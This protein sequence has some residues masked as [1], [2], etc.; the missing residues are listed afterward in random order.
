MLVITRKAD[1]EIVIGDDIR[2][3]VTRIQG[4]RVRIGIDAPKHVRV[5]RAE[6][7]NRRERA[8]IAPTQAIHMFPSFQF[9]A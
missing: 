8:P 1:D 2:I 3:V 6:I 4:D 7:A 5:D 9:T